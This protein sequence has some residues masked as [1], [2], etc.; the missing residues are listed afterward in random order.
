MV[1]GFLF[2]ISHELNTPLTAVLGFTQILSRHI[3]RLNVAQDSPLLRTCHRLETSVLRLQELLA[4]ILLA[5]RILSGQF[6]L[7][8]YFA[9]IGPIVKEVT[10][11]FSEICQ[12][13]NLELVVENIDALPS[14]LIDAVQMKVVFKSIISNAIKYTP[15]GGRITIV[16]SLNKQNIQ[17][18]I[19]DTGIGIDVE[20][21]ERIFDFFHVA[22]SLSHYSSNKSAFGGGGLGLGLPICKGIMTTLG[23]QIWVESERHDEENMPGTTFYLS[24]PIR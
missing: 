11:E 21:Q 7:T 13:R 10:Q 19:R 4:D 2:L 18:A 5:F 1:I 6:Y 20:Q 17:V 8:P 12:N 23:G 3:E 22:G 24:L 9:P 15:D 14:I 16:G